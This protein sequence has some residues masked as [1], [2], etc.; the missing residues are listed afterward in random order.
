MTRSAI[1]LA[2]ALLVTPALADED[3]IRLPP[4]DHAATA[5]ECGACHLVF[6]PQMLPARSWTRIMEGLDDHFGEN[7]SLDQAARDE[8]AAYLASRAADTPGAP[9]ARRFLRRL[10][11]HDVPIRIT[12]IPWWVRAHDEIRP[13]RYTS[14]KVKSKANCI[15]CHRTADKGEYFEEEED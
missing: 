1:I 2:G 8:I 11:Q 4:V 14:E 6:P 5:K 3:G 7:A 9:G 12:E 15:A 13:A 10:G